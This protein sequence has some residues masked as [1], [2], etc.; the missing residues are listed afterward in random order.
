MKRFLAKAGTGTGSFF[1]FLAILG[2]WSYV[3]TQWRS[4][5]GYTVLA[6][7]IFFYIWRFVVQ[8]F[9]AGLRKDNDNETSRK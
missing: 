9:R 8:P 1:C 5:Y 7:L 6:A 4:P 3:S 2:L